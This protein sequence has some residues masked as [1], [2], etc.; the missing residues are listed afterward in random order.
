MGNPNQDGFGQPKPR[1]QPC[2]KK[3]LSVEEKT[4]G[5][6]RLIYY[7]KIEIAILKF[8]FKLEFTIN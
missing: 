8:I 7:N 6:I 3:P 2:V 5:Q 1:D 4:T